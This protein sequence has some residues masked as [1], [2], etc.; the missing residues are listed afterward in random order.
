MPVAADSRSLA[1]DYIQI[2][3][4]NRTP[5][6]SPVGACPNFVV[7]NIPKAKGIDDAIAHFRQLNQSPLVLLVRKI[8]LTQVDDTPI[9]ISSNLSDLWLNKT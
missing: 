5:N 1:E 9:P 3:T 2:P 7:A 4:A 8:A 6:Q